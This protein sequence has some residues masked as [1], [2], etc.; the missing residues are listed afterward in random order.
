MTVQIR[1][2]VRAAWPARTA[3]RDRLYAFGF[4]AYRLVPALRTKPPGEESPIAGVTGKLHL[5]EHNRVRRELEW[6]QSKAAPTLTAGASTGARH[7]PLLRSPDPGRFV[8]T[9]SESCRTSPVDRRRRAPVRPLSAAARRYLPGCADRH[10]EKRLL[11]HAFLGSGSGQF[12]DGL[13]ERL[14]R[15]REGAPVDTQA[16]FRTQVQMQ[17]HRLRQVHVLRLHKPSRQACADRYQ[18]QIET[19]ARIR[20]L[21][22]GEVLSRIG[23]VA[24]IPRVARKEPMQVRAE[25]RPGAPQ[26]LVA[27]RQRAPRPVLRRGAMK[28]DAGNLVSLPPVKFEGALDALLRQNQDLSPKGV[29]NSGEPPACRESARMLSR[30]K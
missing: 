12:M 7:G 25:Y 29:K 19:A 5:D 2:S 23:E 14:I 8:R 6:A 17:L 11:A 21:A 15:Q 26:G 28:F 30:S 3:R 9:R 1:D 22:R 4:D 13:I 16:A 10:D 24:A 20:R 18:R 27:I